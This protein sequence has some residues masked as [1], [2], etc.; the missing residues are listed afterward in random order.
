MAT[1]T[2]MYQTNYKSNWRSKIQQMKWHPLFLVRIDTTGLDAATDRVTG[3]SIAKIALKDDEFVM[4]DSFVSLVNSGT[5]ISPEIEQMYGITNAQLEK[6]PT[7][8]VVFKKVV[9]FLGKDAFVV[10]L[11]TKDFLGPFLMAEAKR[12]GVELPVT[13]SLDLTQMA[14]SLVYQKKN[15]G[16][17]YI[18][19]LKRFN[20]KPGT[21]LNGFVTLFNKL[22]ELIP[23]GTEQT[24]VNNTR[25]WSIAYDRRYIFFNTPCGDVRL[26]CTTGFWEEKTPGFFDMVDMDAL[27]DYVLMRL[28]CNHIWD[29]IKRLTPVENQ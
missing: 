28:N 20:I 22:Y 8:D 13:G 9:E 5:K 6:A 24:K 27:T 4:E 1:E 10:G 11:M 21:G 12:A 19:L 25:Y 29:A 3:I 16:Y 23:T 14:K 15:E 17:G 2:R 26:N 7:S 18:A